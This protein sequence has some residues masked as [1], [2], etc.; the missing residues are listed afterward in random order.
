[1]S[2]A[3]RDYLGANALGRAL[4]APVFDNREQ[5]ANSA[6]CT[7]LEFAAADFYPE[8]DRVATELV[9]H[10]RSEAGRT[11]TTASCRT[12]SASCR[13]AALSSACAGRRTTCAFTAPATKQIHHPVVGELD[14]VYE[15]ME[16][17]ADQGLSIAVFTA[18]PARPPS[19]HSTCSPAGRRRRLRPTGSA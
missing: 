11:P 4:Y 2:N 15:S 14:L 16:L 19:R 1:V 3:R 5:P 9:A 8:W 18:E 12:S 6:G 10:Q 13:C 17:G 7:F